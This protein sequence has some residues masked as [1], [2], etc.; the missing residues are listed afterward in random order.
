MALTL[1]PG[2]GAFYLWVL[3]LSY[4]YSIHFEFF[5][6]SF[7]GL[8]GEYVPWFSGGCYSPD[9]FTFSPLR[10]FL[11]VEFPPAFSDHF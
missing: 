9:L 5:I 6:G 2:V 4:T 11:R 3:I 1:I 10:H 7:L 8:C